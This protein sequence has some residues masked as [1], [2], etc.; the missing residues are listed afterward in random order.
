M[1]L[2]HVEGAPIGLSLLA[3]HRAD[4]YLMAAVRRLCDG[5]S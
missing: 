5:F 1:P 3:A 4:M 2:G